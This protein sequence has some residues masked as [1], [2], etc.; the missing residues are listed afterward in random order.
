MGNA[1]NRQQIENKLFEFEIFLDSNDY[2]AYYE[3]GNQI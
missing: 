3:R 2:V 1:V